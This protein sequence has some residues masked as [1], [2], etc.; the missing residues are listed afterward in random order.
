[1]IRKG[2][3]LWIIF[4]LGFSFSV[5]GQKVN[6]SPAFFGPNALPVPEVT[7]GRIPNYT[8]LGFSSDYSFGFGDRTLAWRWDAEVPLL[9]KFVSIKVWMIA[10]ENYW[11][12]PEISQL[13]DINPPVSSGWA[14]G[15]VYVQTRISVLREKKYSPQIIIAAAI[16]TASGGKFQERRYYDTPG[17]YFDAS[18][19]KS[20]TINSKILNDIRLVGNVGFLCWETTNS[21][22]NDAPM[23]GLNFILSNALFTFENQVGGYWGWMNNGDRPLTYRTKLTYNHKFLD[24]FFQYQYGIMDFPYHQI[25]LGF[26]VPIQK[27]TPKYPIKSKSESD[28]L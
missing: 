24:I 28:N 16:I 9:P 6:Y 22:Q 17:Y 21:T 15:D 10:H 27:L 3:F 11:L 19:A 5:L 12:T 23:Y 7:D 20:F 18:I 14:T 25:R 13:R 2:I 4:L 26:L 1:M 8:Q